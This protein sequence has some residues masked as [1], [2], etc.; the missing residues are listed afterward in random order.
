MLNVRKVIQRTSHYIETE[1]GEVE[2]QFEPLEHC[3]MHAERVGDK[4]VVAYLVSDGD[5]SSCYPMDN[6]G[7]GDIY[8]KASA[9]AYRSSITDNDAELYSA[10]G[11]H[12]DGSINDESVLTIDNESNS[13]IGHAVAYFMLTNYGHELTDEWL[14]YFGNDIDETDDD[15]SIDN[16]D[17]LETDM[18]DGQFKEEEIAAIVVTLYAKHWKQIV[19]PYVLPISCSSGH[20]TSISVT[21]WDGDPD[22]LPD[23]VW[24]ANKDAIENINANPLPRN[25]HVKYSHREKAWRVGHDV[26]GGVNQKFPDHEAAATFAHTLGPGDIEWAAEL[27]ADSILK[28]YAMWCNGEV[29][30]CCVETFELVPDADPHSDAP[31]V[32]ERVK[33]DACWGFIG[34]EYA[35]QSLLDDFFTPAVEKAAK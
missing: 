12:S 15:R 3:D 2:V 30:G 23:G 1:Y 25:V 20:E 14:E 6:C 13:L 33:D 31:T 8:T 35:E 16:R 5:G 10:L 22:E 29:Y 17:E 32:W 11:L 19:G 24:V 18:I 4:L 26:P 7:Q 27:Y 28:E 34:D 21:T 9:Y